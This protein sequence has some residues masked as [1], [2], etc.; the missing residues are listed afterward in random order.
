MSIMV[1]AD[2]SQLEL[3]IAAALSKDPVMIDILRHDP[4][5]PEGDMHKITAGAITGLPPAQV[6]SS[7]RKQAKVVNYLAN[8]D[9]REDKLIEGIERK[10]LEDTDSGLT[11]PTKLEARRMLDAHHKL[12]ERYWQW[13]R[14]TLVRVRENGYAETAF[15]RPR[16]FPDITSRDDGLR[17]EAERAACNHVIQG[18]A[19]D[20]L[21]MAMVRVSEDAWMARAGDMVLQVHDEIVSI[22]HR[23]E[24]VAAYC[25][26]LD[27][28]MQ[29]GQ[30]FRPDVELVVDIGTGKSWFECHK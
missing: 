11:V 14:W 15:G 1:A 12:Y 23:E 5:T 27:H 26:R 21:K 18:T 8:Y 10:V 4:N 6:S 2:M 25:E 13:K 29:C 28:Y 20:L 24:D 9:G 30:P 3:R 7:W 19:A 16:Y 17:K 22:V